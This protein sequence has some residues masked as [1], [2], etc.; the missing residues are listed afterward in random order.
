MLRIIIG[1]MWSGKTFQVIRLARRYRAI[2]KKVLFV[3]HISDVRYKHEGSLQPHVITHDGISEKGMFVEKLM[4][5]LDTEEYVTADVVIIEEAQFF[6]DLAPFIK[7]ETD[8]HLEKDYI[9]SGLAGDFQRRPIGDILTL[10]PYADILDKLN[11]MCQRCA[12]GTPGCFTR[13]TQ[14]DDHQIV[15]GGKGIY[16]CVCRRHLLE[17]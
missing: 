3:D 1:P 8:R 16:E 5:I 15:V 14:P 11:G 10:V 4:E 17:E 13:K 6:Q 12:D 9:V 2:G 7:M